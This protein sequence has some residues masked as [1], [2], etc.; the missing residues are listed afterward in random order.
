M[1][2]CVST[3]GSVVSVE[4]SR[5]EIEKHAVC[6]SC[7]TMALLT[8]KNECEGNPFLPRGRYSELSDDNWACAV[9]TSGHQ[10]ATES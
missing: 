6:C 10:V 4:R 7:V 5:Y 3:N 9:V 1:L 2:T 8:E